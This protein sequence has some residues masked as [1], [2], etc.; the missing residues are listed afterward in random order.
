MAISLI[1]AFLSGLTILLARTINSQLRSRIGMKYTLLANYLTG[2]IGA[3][4]V[5]LIGGGR[6]P[7]LDRPLSLR[8]A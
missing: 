5:F 4:L 7:T 2:T 1:L 8:D 6:V 3:F